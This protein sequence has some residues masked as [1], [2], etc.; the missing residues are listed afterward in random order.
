M[1]EGRPILCNW[2]TS[3]D[4]CERIGTRPMIACKWA[5]S[6]CDYLPLFFA[7]S[8]SSEPNDES[9]ANVDAAVSLVHLE[10]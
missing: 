1:D 6:L 7:F 2:Y 4:M 8:L 5:H 3:S 9:P 10:Y